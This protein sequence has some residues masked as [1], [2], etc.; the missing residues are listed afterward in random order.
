MKQQ[1]SGKT[2]QLWS[3]GHIK[4]WPRT[5]RRF[6]SMERLDK[7]TSRRLS[8]SPAEANP[9]KC[10]YLARLSWLVAVREQGCWKLGTVER[11]VAC[12]PPKDNRA[13]QPTGPE[14]W[15]PRRDPNRIGSRQASVNLSGHGPSLVRGPRRNKGQSRII[16]DTDPAAR[17]LS[18][19]LGR[20]AL[21]RLQRRGHRFE[22]CHAHHTPPDQRLYRFSWLDSHRVG[23]HDFGTAM[24][25]GG[26]AHHCPWNDFG[27]SGEQA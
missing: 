25:S 26:R 9:Y 2:W 14:A 5:Q 24:H 20:G 3:V 4:C 19:Q 10:G 7:R 16:S 27:W 21:C 6:T 15:P 8:T 22:P 1:P 13:P 18:G 23:A 12:K 17:R 11:L